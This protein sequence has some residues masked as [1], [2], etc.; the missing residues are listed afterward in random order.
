M[1]TW[2]SS[3]VQILYCLIEILETNTAS[4]LSKLWWSCSTSS[5]VQPIQFCNRHFCCRGLFRALCSSFFVHTDV[6]NLVWRRD[7]DQAAINLPCVEVEVGDYMKSDS[8]EVAVAPCGL[9]AE[10]GHLICQEVQGI[11]IPETFSTEQQFNNSIFKAGE[12][13]QHEVVNGQVCVRERI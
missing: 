4:L 10:S 13:T 8:F 2:Q 11:R 5:N 9:M 6:I 1:T 12:I 3:Q 7:Q